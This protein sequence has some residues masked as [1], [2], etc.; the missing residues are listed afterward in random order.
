MG[1]HVCAVIDEGW[2][3]EGLVASRDGGIIRM[4]DANVVRRWDN[5]LGIGAIADPEHKDDYT[6]DHIGNVSVYES[7]VLFE[8]PMGW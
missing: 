4:K 6:L 1:E 3:I 7:R 2:I 5:G 8:I